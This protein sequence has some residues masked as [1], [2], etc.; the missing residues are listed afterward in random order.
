MD[1]C[2]I[3]LEPVRVKREGFWGAMSR[4]ELD[5]SDSVSRFLKEW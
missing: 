5:N 3:A 2:V 1:L 4:I